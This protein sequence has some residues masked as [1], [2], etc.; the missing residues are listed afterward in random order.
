M[1]YGVHMIWPWRPCCDLDL[2]SAESNLVITKG[3]WIFVSCQFY[4]ICSS[5]PETSW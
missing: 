1:R 2:W 3:Y 4:G 5:V